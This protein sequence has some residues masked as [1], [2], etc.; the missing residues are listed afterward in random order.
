MTKF[1][2][3]GLGDY[4]SGLGTTRDKM[5]SAA[6]VDRFLSDWELM[7]A[8]RSAWLPRRIVDIPAED[9]TNEGRDWQASADQIELIEAEENRLGLWQKLADVQSKARL[10]GG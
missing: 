3:D 7:N 1:L 4:V 2:N 9:S 10:F 5:A 6:Y 8:Y